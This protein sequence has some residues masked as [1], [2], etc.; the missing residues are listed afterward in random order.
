MPKGSRYM[1]GSVITGLNLHCLQTLGEAAV[2][3]GDP[4]V[5][6]KGLGG[7]GQNSKLSPVPATGKALVLCPAEVAASVMCSVPQSP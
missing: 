4:Q 3:V 7:G 6:A 5:V 1:A 2:V